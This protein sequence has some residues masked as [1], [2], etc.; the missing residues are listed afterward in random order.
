MPAAT[1]ATKT[2]SSALLGIGA[3]HVLWATGSSWPLPT[4][5]ELADTVAGRTSTTAPRAIDCLAVAGLLT[6][7]A[8]FVSGRPRRAPRFGR[9]GAAGV[10]ATLGVRGGFGLA[11]RTDMLVP[12][13]SS[14]HFR[15]MDRQFYSPLCLSI[16][17]L[18]L[19]AVAKR[20]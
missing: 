3:L 4:H 18:A 19:P 10:V 5:A 6:A 1:I 16:A 20:V 8:A 15:R 2:S 12:G 17:A 7:A 13:S 9:L 11:G 14:E